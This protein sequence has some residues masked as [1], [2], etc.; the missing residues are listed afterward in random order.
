[1][2][3]QKIFTKWLLLCS[4]PGETSDKPENFHKMA[5]MFAQ[6]KN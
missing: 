4:Q 1:M 2:I 6:N 3:S 5:A